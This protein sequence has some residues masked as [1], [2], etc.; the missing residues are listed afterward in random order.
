MTPTTETNFVQ[1]IQSELIRLDLTTETNPYTGLIC[2]VTDDLQV[3]LYDD[4]EKEVY[5]PLCLLEKLKGLKSA[6]LDDDSP[7]NIWQLIKDCEL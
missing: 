5:S 4:F 2:D 1:A 7:E 6:S 3:L